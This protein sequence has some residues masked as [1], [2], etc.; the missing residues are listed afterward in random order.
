MLIYFVR[1]GQ[2]PSNAE[3]R[4]Q[5]AETP[6]SA[7]GEIQ[8]NKIAERLKHLDIDEIWTSPMRRAQHTAEIINQ[9]HQVPLTEKP[10]LKELKRATVFE[11]KLVSDPSIQHIKDKILEKSEDPFFAYEDGESLA[12]LVDRAKRVISELE[13]Y[14]DQKNENNILC[15]T[16]HGIVLSTILTTILLGKYATPHHVRETLSH[17]RIENTGISIVST[18]HDVWK[19][20]TLNDFAHL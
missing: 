11:G 16:T 4:F 12:V 6:L 9:Y 3:K 2:T 19:I 13:Q 7:E 17:F 20:L 18:H 1:H 10:E 14:A 15:V 5:T 8:A